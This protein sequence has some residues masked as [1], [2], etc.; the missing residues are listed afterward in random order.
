M[1]KLAAYQ[2]RAVGL[3][4]DYA[5]KVLLAILTLIVGLWLVSKALSVFQSVLE[6]R[7]VDATL[8]PFL[9]SLLGWTLK[10]IVFISVASMVGIKTTSFI[11]LLGAAGLA[12][13]L[14]LQGSLGNFAGGTL[15][16]IFRP[17]KVGDLIEA[18]GQ[19][20]V[21]KEIQIFT[22]S[23][24]SPQH[25][26]VIIPNGKMAN[27]TIVNFTAE[28]LLRVDLTIGIS[29]K[30][31][32]DRATDVLLDILENDARVVEEPPPLVAV[33]GL[34][35]SSVNLAVRPHCRPEDYW[36]VYFDTLKASKQALDA[37]GIGI[38]F[39]QRDIHVHQVGPKA[40]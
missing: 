36:D 30:A 28:G 21:V 14:A 24:V 27:D 4:M 31:D 35:D 12:I 6:R 1:D 22:T 5:P 10:A 8:V 18:Q 3:G 19:I 9:A 34:A 2:D 11:A 26:L 40:A 38:P 39:P 32:I 16:L 29:Y 20:G 37:A 25:R 23:L 33:S 15:I 17:Y 13:G 7:G